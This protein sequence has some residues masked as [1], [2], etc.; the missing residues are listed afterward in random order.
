MRHNYAIA[1]FFSFLFFASIPTSSACGYDWIGECSSAIHLRINGTLDSFDIA[2]CP[3]G[4]R[5]DGLHLGTLQNLALANAKAVTWES[6][7][8]N[9]SAVGL[10]YRLYEQGGGV[11]AF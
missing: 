10:K 1:F 8:N 5:F 11:W 7:Q 4:I 3:A 9:V 2:E 6:C